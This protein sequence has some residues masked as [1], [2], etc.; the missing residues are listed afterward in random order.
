MLV[1][2]TDHEFQ[3]LQEWWKRLVAEVPPDAKAATT[4]SSATPVRTSTVAAPA[5]IASPTAGTRAVPTRS[6]AVA[7]PAPARDQSQ[8]DLRG[9]HHGPHRPFAMPGRRPPRGSGASL[10]TP[11]EA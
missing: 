3:V 9:G 6:T 1:Q 11:H 10:P 4:C 8:D 5:G 7:G 2:P